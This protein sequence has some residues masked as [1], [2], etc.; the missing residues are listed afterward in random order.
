V[1]SIF[2]A[3]VAIFQHFWGLSLLRLFSGNE[4]KLIAGSENRYLATG[5]AFHHN[6]FSFTM[7]LLLP[8]MVI[9]G[10][11]AEK[12]LRPWFWLAAF[13]CVICVGLS[14]S[15]S[16]WLCLV[17]S[18]F[19]LLFF[20]R[21]KLLAPLGVLVSG[22]VFIL[23][24]YYPEFR[25]RFS[26]INVSA[27]SERL[28]LW[29][30]CIKMFKDSPIL[31]QGFYSFGSRHQKYMNLAEPRENFPV[32]A[33]NMYLDMLSGT[34]ILGL[35]VFLFFIGSVFKILWNGIYRNSDL[36]PVEKK[37]FVAMFSSFLVF[38]IGGFFD[39]FF[40]M[41]QSLVPLMFFLGM[42]ISIQMEKRK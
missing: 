9:G 7:N 24:K 6:P 41:T 20:L 3:V 32:E 42:T 10:V 36:N 11:S 33:H 23:Y 19:S 34:G 27:N 25:S 29:K 13:A 15:R 5:F 18:L 1:L 40:Y 38:L 17:A 31:G 35:L 39:K 16:G 37:Y 14:F 30:I 12:R 21:P 2:L 26:S 4:L 22:S 8:F 28:E